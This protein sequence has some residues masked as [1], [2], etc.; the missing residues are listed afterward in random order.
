MYNA[1]ITFAFDNGPAQ[2]IG[3]L[4]V[5]PASPPKGIS[6][7]G[8][9]T[10]LLPLFTSLGSGFST[11]AGWPAAIEV[12]VV[13]DC[14]QPLTAGSVTASF[15][16]NDPPVNLTSLRDGRWSGTWKAQNGA[17]AS[18][19]ITAAARSADGSLTG[20]AQISG[21][22]QIN[23]NPPP[24]V[25][26]GGVLSAASYSLQAALAPGALVSVFGSLFAPQE[27]KVESL[28][29]PVT[30][31]VTTVTI[32]G[33]KLPLLYIGPAQMNAMIPFDLP[34][35]ATHQ[36]VVQRGTAISIPEPIGVVSSQ[37]GVFTRDLTGKGAGI[38]VRVTS[39]GKQALV[40]TDNPAHAFD[41]L[42]IYCSG[43]GDV[44]PQQIAGSAA[45]PTP[46]SRALDTVKVTIGGIDAP[47]I[48][49]GLTPGFTGLYQINAYVPV[50]VTPGDNV[51]LI[52]TQAGRS[53]PPVTISVR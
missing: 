27:T 17:G 16:N 42:V 19:T 14:G 29:L 8:G 18:V 15:S 47:L 34:I 11:T 40:G 48:F 53:S 38:V 5:L 26:P 49:A 41:A 31:G 7:A 30:L 9:C 46:L 37:S 44:D 28:P 25:A 23:S 4:L 10:R 43:L 50:G 3:L 45:P 51:P 20:S 39:D 13:D 2:N 52:I 6:P 1:N 32:A 12:Q 24:V 35:N 21:G 33:R 36:V 22:L